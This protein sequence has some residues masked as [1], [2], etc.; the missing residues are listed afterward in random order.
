MD[1]IDLSQF[2][3]WKEPLNEQVVQTWKAAMEKDRGIPSPVVIREA[4]GRYTPADADSA[5]R[6]EAAS[7]LGEKSVPCYIIDAAELSPEKREQLWRE[8]TEL[9]KH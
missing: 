9:K 8:L 2:D 7:R 1:N 6:L 5:C 3:D 4:N